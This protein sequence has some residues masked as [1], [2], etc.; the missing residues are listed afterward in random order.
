MNAAVDAATAE[1]AVKPRAR[2]WRW[3][4]I[5]AGPVLIAAVVAYVI[6]TGGRFETTDD[7]YVQ[8]AKAPVAPAISG[9]V[10]WFWQSWWIKNLHNALKHTNNGDVSGNR[11]QIAIGSY[12]PT[13]HQ[14][15]LLSA[16]KKSL[17]GNAF[18]CV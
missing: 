10:F 7:A 2:H 4:L 9:R 16:E 1:S 12:R 3:I 14:V 11:S 6:L 17:L 13:S 18:Y 15:H 8:I 5:L